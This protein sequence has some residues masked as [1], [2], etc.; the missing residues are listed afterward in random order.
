MNHF[1]TSSQLLKRFHK[2]IQIVAWLGKE[3]ALENV[4]LDGKCYNI[5]NCSRNCKFPWKLGKI[6]CVH[7]KSKRSWIWLAITQVSSAKS[8]ISLKNNFQSHTHTHGH[9]SAT[10]W[11]T[12]SNTRTHICDNHTSLHIH[13]HTHGVCLSMKDQN[14]VTG[15]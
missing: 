15:V 1:R 3:K 14:C 11:H 7:T 8:R 5:L 9:E 10:P 6:E 2:I 4:F 13:Q 12:R